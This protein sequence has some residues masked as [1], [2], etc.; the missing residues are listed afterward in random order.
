MTSNTHTRR[1]SN[2]RSR[3]RKRK[4]LPEVTGKSGL[5]N[6]VLVDAA[7]GTRRQPLPRIST[8]LLTELTPNKAADTV[9]H[10]EHHNND[11][12]WGLIR[13]GRLPSLRQTCVRPGWP[14]RKPPPLPAAKQHRRKR[15]RSK[16]DSL[17][18]YCILGG[19][20][21]KAITTPGRNLFLKSRRLYKRLWIKIANQFNN[22]QTT[23]P[24]LG[25]SCS[26]ALMKDR[27]NLSNLG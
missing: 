25:K 8:P 12:L 24:S 1:Q 4:H 10:G 26:P 19:L 16:K 22:S 11:H 3:N 18:R 15:R 17:K 23:N 6:R 21:S 27:E 5:S 13:S 20:Q 7:P 14:Q 2:R 9:S